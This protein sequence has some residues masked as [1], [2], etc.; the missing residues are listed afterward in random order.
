MFYFHFL[1]LDQPKEPKQT[2][3]ERPNPMKVHGQTT[4]RQKNDSLS[5]ESFPAIGQI[6]HRWKL[7]MVVKRPKST[8]LSFHNSIKSTYL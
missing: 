8:N 7:S 6:I 2:R 4:G 5:T 1:N 3:F